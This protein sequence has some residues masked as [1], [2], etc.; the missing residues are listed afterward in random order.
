MATLKVKD[1]FLAKYKKLEDALKVAKDGDII[2]CAEGIYRLPSL[3][4]IPNVTINAK[5]SFIDIH[6]PKEY[7]GLLK[8][9]DHL[10]RNLTI[11]NAKLRITENTF[12]ISGKGSLTLN[13]CALPP[14]IFHIKGVTLNIINPKH[15]NI[16]GTE[17]K[18]WL[19]LFISAQR[20][21]VNIKEASRLSIQLRAEHNSKFRFSNS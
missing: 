10:K 18:E 13:G 6:V 4:H 16:Y 12:A 3:S 9:I 20:S 2:N 7:D 14:T 21:K 5:N 19:P 15:L 17:A 1:S 8:G 11:N